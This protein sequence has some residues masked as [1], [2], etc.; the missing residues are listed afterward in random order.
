MT[1]SMLRF[2]I[3]ASLLAA[4]MVAGVRLGAIGLSTSDVLHALVGGGD[5]TT[6]TIVLG[7]RLPRV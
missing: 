2:A 6:Q 7:L 5:A 3:L 1:R 4:A